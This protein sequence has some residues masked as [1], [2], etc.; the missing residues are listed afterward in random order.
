[1]RKGGGA[2][3]LLDFSLNSWSKQL[4]EMR[5]REGREE[6]RE[7]G[8]GGR[9]KGS[10]GGGQGRGQGGWKGGGQGEWKGGGKS[11]GKRKET[12]YGEGKRERRMLMA[13]GWEEYREGR[14]QRVDEW[15]LS[16]S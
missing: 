13:R 7:R 12:W 6:G 9:G 3:G 4:S 2:P 10:W 1:M 8:Q 14:K 11:R 15:V 5:G 16:C